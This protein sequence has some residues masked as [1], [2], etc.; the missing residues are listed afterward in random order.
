MKILTL[1]SKF[2]IWYSFQ[3]FANLNCKKNKEINVL[4]ST[5]NHHSISFFSMPN[6]HQNLYVI[7]VSQNSIWN[8]YRLLHT[9]TVN[10]D[11]ILLVKPCQFNV[12]P[13]ILKFK[14]QKWF[15]GKTWFTL[16]VRPAQRSKCYNVHSL[17][18]VPTFVLH[19]C[20]TTPGVNDDVKRDSFGFQLFQSLLLHCLTM[21]KEI[22]L[23]LWLL[24][25]SK[26]TIALPCVNDD[27][28]VQRRFLW[29]LVFQAFFG[30]EN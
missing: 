7:V 3:Y 18:K 23:V 6:E 17:V 26:S 10:E 19:H 2:Y 24:V 12:Q 25:I 1:N 4:F 28:L 30:L 8:S 15:N 14:F 9:K 27:V 16:S 5:I 21:F 20:S 29:L 22:F 13:L 11:F